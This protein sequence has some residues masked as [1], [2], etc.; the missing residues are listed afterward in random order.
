L[1]IRRYAYIDFRGPFK[2][3]RNW[4]LGTDAALTVIN[5]RAGKEI[6]VIS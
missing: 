4:G 1:Y 6:R 5:V 2:R 3:H